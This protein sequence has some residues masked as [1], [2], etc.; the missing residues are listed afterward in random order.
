MSIVI[1]VFEFS[2]SPVPVRDDLKGAYARLW[3][4]FAEP[5]P[6]LTGTQRV[7]IAEYVRAARSGGTPQPADLHPALLTLVA[8]LFV[9]PARV[10]RSMVRQSAEAV[11]DPMV[12][13]VISIVSMLSAVDGAH[14]ALGADLEPLPSPLAGEPTSEIAKGLKQRQ[15]HVPMPAGAIPVSLD[16]L[17]RIGQVFQN[18]FGSQYMTESEMAFADFKRT[19]GLD[20][21]QIE[22]VSSRTSL[23]N[24]CFY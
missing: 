5:G 13:E 24:K 18:S 6:T 3:S 8:T 19:P 22:I 2:G 17:P 14:T 7:G 20:R 12:V 9:D 16:L 11:G 1:Q 4:H 10:D 23:R 15:T 21:A